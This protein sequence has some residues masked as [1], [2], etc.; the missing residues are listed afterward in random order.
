MNVASNPPTGE[1]SLPTSQEQFV[2]TMAALSGIPTGETK[3]ASEKGTLREPL[4]AMVRT[5]DVNAQATVWDSGYSM[6]A[7]KHLDAVNQGIFNAFWTGDFS[8]AVPAAWVADATSSVTGLERMDVT[9]AAMTA[10]ILND[11]A[12]DLRLE[13][14]DMQ[15]EGTID[16]AGMETD[17]RAFISSSVPVMVVLNEGVVELKID[18][19]RTSRTVW[20]VTGGEAI[21]VMPETL[22][23]GLEALTAS[24]SLEYADAVLVSLP[25]VAF[26]LAAMF[27][28][29]RGAAVVMMPETVDAAEGQIKMAG[30][31]LPD[32]VEPSNNN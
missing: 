22:S 7:I 12:G 1:K 25:G 31:P 23:A 20:E 5:C 26:D 21:N 17:F 30:Q 18:D 24:F 10:P 29:D 2:N 11:C 13:W 19:S 28:I 6:D 3:T 4:G 14:A 27:D 16:E 15:V 9:V 8:G 32:G